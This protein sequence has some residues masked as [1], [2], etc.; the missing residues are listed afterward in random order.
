MV[1][2]MLRLVLLLCFASSELHRTS[3]DNSISSNTSSIAGFGYELTMTGLEGIQFRT[4]ANNEKMLVDQRVMLDDFGAQIKKLSNTVETMEDVPRIRIQLELLAHNISRL[5]EDTNQIHRT[6]Q[7]QPT[8]EMLNDMILSLL[9]NRH[10]TARN[11]IV[12]ESSK[13]PRTCS[14]VSG[15]WSGVRKLHPEPGFGDPFEAYCD[16]DYEGGGWTVIQNRFN[17]TVYFYRGWAEYEA[18][19]GDLEGEFWLG[20]KK[21]HQLTNAK[22]HELHVVLEDFEGGRVVAKYGRMV[23]GGGSEKYALNSL[24]TYSGDAGDSLSWAVGNKFTTLDADHDSHPPDN[25]ATMY[26]GGWWYG[27]CHGSNLNGL[28]VK[29]KTEAYANMMCWDKFKGLNYGL[30]TSRMMIRATA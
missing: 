1:L 8:T 22:P 13:L 3:A 26:K 20:L 2:K 9:A 28:Y 24:G 10:P 18:G 14:D 11:G 4:V 12:L 27:A 21:L 16:Q 7:V 30:K 25:C 6:Q 29:G 17:G 19:F 23:V 5:L 15:H